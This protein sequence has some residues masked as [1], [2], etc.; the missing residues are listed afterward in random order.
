MLRVESPLCSGQQ[1][2]QSQITNNESEPVVLKAEHVRITRR[3]PSKHE[4][5][6]HSAGFWFRR[7]VGG[8]HRLAC[9]ASSRL[10]VQRPLSENLWREPVPIVWSAAPMQP[11]VAVGSSRLASQTLKGCCGQR[12]D[13][14]EGSMHPMPR[15]HQAPRSEGSRAARKKS[16]GHS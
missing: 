9:L 14:R 3:P 11:G 16:L 1:G 4:P 12:G 10:L 13:V 2:T 5:L 8:S 7:P 6:P 15:R